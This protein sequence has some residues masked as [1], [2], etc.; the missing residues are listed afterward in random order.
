MP[1][2]YLGSFNQRGKSAISGKSRPWLLFS[3][4]MSNSDNQLPASSGT[5]TFDV[6]VILKLQSNVVI[7]IIQM[8][9]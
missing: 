5:F 3:K 2:S 7:F 9:L 1:E 4:P 6:C 8:K